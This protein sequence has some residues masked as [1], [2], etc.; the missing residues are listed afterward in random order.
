IRQLNREIMA[1]KT[2]PE[3][4]K[5]KLMIFLSEVDFRV[6]EGA[7]GDVQLAAMLAKLVEVGESHERGSLGGEVQ[8]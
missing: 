7:H 8:T 3:R 5:A 6:T 1:S 2:I 4:E